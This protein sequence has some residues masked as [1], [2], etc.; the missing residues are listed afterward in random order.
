[1]LMIQDQAGNLLLEQRP[2]KGIWGGLWSLPECPM[3][4]EPATWCADQLGV[5]GDISMEWESRRHTFTH[6][7]LDIVPVEIRTIS[8]RNRVMDGDRLVWYNTATPDTREFTS[9]YQAQ[10]GCHPLAVR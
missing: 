3:E 9:F 10:P 7:H 4:E 1:M 2:S 8:N 6:F 5:R